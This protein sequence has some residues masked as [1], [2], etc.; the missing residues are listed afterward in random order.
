MMGERISR[1]Q[2]GE[3]KEQGKGWLPGWKKEGQG[4][5]AV[6]AGVV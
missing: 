5:F 1:K 4:T 6:Y 2:E 3:W